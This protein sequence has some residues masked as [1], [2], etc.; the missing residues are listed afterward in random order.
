MPAPLPLYTVLPFVA[1]LLAIALFPLWLPHWWESNRSKLV[2]VAVL[3]A[4]VLVLYLSRLPAA[5]VHM[6]GDYV[7]FIILLSG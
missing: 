1:M 4:P 2:V 6:A 7:S 5:L 3:G